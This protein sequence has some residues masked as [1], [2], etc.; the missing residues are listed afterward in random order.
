MLRLR[1]TAAVVSVV[2]CVAAY[3]LAGA[4]STKTETEPYVQEQMPAGFQIVNTELEG[5]VFA[6][7]Q[8]HTMY[9]WPSQ[10]QRNGNLGELPGKPLCNDVHYRETAGMAIPY[11]A[12]LE[13]PNADNRP[14]CIQHWPPVYAA[15]DAQ[16]VGNFT[17]LERT[18]GTKQWAYKE[19]AL[20]T[21]HLDHKAGDTWGGTRRIVGKDPVSAGAKRLPAKPAP[22]VPPKFKVITNALGRMLLTDTDYS[23][24]SYDKDTATT[25]NC[26]GTCAIDFDP[27]LA[28][29]TSVARGDWAVIERPGGRKQWTFR[30]KPLYRYLKDMKER[31]QDGSDQPGWHNVFLQRTPNPPRGFQT[32]VT[33]GGKIL[34]DP[35]GKTIYWYSCSEDTLDTLVCDDVNSPQEYRL[36]ACGAGDVN[37]CLTTFPY[38]IADKTAKSDSTVWSI[39]DIDPKTGHY[40]AAGTPGSLHVWA[41]RE[42]PIYTFSGD[43]E[44]GDLGADVWGEGFGEKNGFSAFWVRDLFIGNQGGID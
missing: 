30:G 16:P 35:T 24:Y 25:S 4:A 14:T 13:L 17:V 8:G 39:K 21:S 34:A 32:V 9:T 26:T 38:V 11:P 43:K 19:Y 44:P 6:D 1:I 40:V 28:S 27:L 23:V 5:P 41:F 22:M 33:D 20:Y 2:G 18:D 42:R 31:A 36:A 7:A 3:G 15:A 10:T 12:G 29:D 37:R